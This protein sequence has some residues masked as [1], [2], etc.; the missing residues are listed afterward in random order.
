MLDQSKWSIL[1]CLILILGLSVAE[2]EA[3]RRGRGRKNSKSKK[4]DSKNKMEDLLSLDKT[5]GTPV[6]ERTGKGLSSFLNVF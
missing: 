5:S 6:Q 4:F 3:S 2:P 1:L